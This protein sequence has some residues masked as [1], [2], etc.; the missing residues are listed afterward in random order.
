MTPDEMTR[1]M[2]RALELAQRGWGRVAPNPMVGAVVVRDG[3]LV[4]EGWHREYGQPHAEVEALRMAGP[5]ARGA[6][7][8]V[9]L[10]PCTHYGKTPPCTEAIMAAG[11]RR[12]VYGASD[13]NPNAKGGGDLLWNAGVEVFGGFLGQQARDLNPAFIHL[14][15][16]SGRPFVALKLAMTLD[17]RIADRDG[18]SSWITGEESRAEVHRLRAGF[19]AVAVGIGTARADDPQLTVRG[20]VEPRVVPARVVFDRNLRLAP[21]SALVR[22]A[23]E[24]PVIVVASRQADPKRERTLVEHGVNVLRAA[25]LGTGLRALREAGVGSMFVEGGSGLAGAL[26]EDGLVDR[27][28]LFYAPL[29]LGPEGL[30]AFGE[31][32]SPTIEEAHRWR[33]ISTRTFGEDTLVTLALR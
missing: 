13:P 4:G 33:R 20:A 26:L 1:W 22:G 6:T 25:D 7:M 9:T 19:D 16:G 30:P 2:A 12:V 24:A 11:V 5:R 15:G 14:H 27:L 32:G 21:D 29:L 28:Y 31:L 3:V 17:A 8:F 23:R 10:E 18:R